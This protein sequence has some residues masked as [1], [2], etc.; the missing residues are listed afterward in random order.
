MDTLKASHPLALQFLLTEDLYSIEA[1][2]KSQVPA[3]ATAVVQETKK[4]AGVEPETAS[5]VDVKEEPLYFEY[6]GENNKYLLILVNSPSHPV[7]DPK[8]LETLLNILK[9]KKQDLKD[10]AVVNLSKYPAATFAGLKQF[11][12]CNSLVLFGINPAQ[13][14]LAAIQANQITVCEN[15]KVLATFSIAEMLNSVD[16]KRAFWDEMKKL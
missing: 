11:F 15:T 12:A 7:I 16:K 13:L 3:A 1:E 4:E 6:L 5:T 9:G 8:E 10:V 14:G 2:V